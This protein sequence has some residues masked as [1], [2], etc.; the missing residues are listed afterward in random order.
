MSFDSAPESSILEIH[1]F[2]VGNVGGSL[3]DQIHRQQ[4]ILRRRGLDLRVCTLGGS[5][6]MLTSD[7]QSDQGLDLK[8]WRSELQA[9]SI[10]SDF[11]GTLQRAQAHRTKTSVL[12]DCSTSPVLATRYADAFRHHLHVVTSNKRTNSGPRADYDEVRTAARRHGQRFLYE[13]NVG[14]GLPVIDT[15]Q[16]LVATGDR[17]LRFEGI[18]SGSLS[19]ILG[20]LES[21]IP[22]SQAVRQALDAGY[23]ESDPREDLSG[24]DAARKLVI[25]A[26]EMGHAL[27]LE[28]LPVQ[29]LLPS[30]FDASGSL[31]EF[32]TRLEN[33]DE[34]FAQRIAKLDGQRLR[35][36]ATW[37][38]TEAQVS[39]RA[40]DPNHPL[41]AIRSA[42]NALC[43]HTERYQPH[44]LIIRG[45]GAGAQ[46]TAAGVLS[47]ILR[48]AA[49]S[50]SLRAGAA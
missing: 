16:N 11:E 27:D 24:L 36:V 40:V 22:F 37:T 28:E 12:V 31:P 9:S 15:L 17:C 44:P 38:P 42:E 43:F 18:L 5:R 46:V 32:L 3:L 39:P 25:L 50:L 30:G 6:R 29:G 45:Y 20:L 47:D 49:P 48:L 1:L 14:A 41:A 2:G 35:Y 33:L 13:T 4:P 23:T 8:N 7:P 34:D 19:F 26:R 10:P 21:G